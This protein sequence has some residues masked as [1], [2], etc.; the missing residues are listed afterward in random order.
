MQYSFQT[1]PEDRIGPIRII[2]RDQT[3]A[4]N[5]NVQIAVGSGSQ[6]HP[7][8]KCFAKGKICNN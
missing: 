4:P 3:T 7:E 2:F 6:N 5:S 1:T 8:K